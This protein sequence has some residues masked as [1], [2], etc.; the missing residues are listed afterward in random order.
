MAEQVEPI[1]MPS[2][3]TVPPRR[4]LDLVAAGRDRSSR[5]TRELGVPAT[6][7]VRLTG[8]L[9]GH[10]TTPTRGV[11]GLMRVDLDRRAVSGI[12]K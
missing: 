3:L 10:L 5:V 1:G 12:W 6:N 9:L 7:P 4:H 8:D 2:W 11:I